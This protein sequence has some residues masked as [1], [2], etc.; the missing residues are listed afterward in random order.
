MKQE[1]IAIVGVGVALLVAL[2][3]FL[4]PLRGDVRI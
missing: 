4:L 3:S 1:T 2:V